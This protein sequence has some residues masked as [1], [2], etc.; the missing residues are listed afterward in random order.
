MHKKTST[1]THAPGL[2]LQQALSSIVQ[3]AASWERT[4]LVVGLPPAQR[5]ERVCVLW[6][7]V[8]VCVWFVNVMLAGLPPA[9]RHERVYVLWVSVRVCV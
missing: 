5:H 4:C 3:A 6:V 2:H 7:S 1:R 8:R 9:Q